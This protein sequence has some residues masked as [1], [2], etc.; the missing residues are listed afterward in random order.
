[1]QATSSGF[2]HFFEFLKCLLTRAYLTVI[3]C[4]LQMEN[5]GKYL[6]FCE[7]QLGVPKGDQFQTVDLYEKQNMANVSIKNNI[8]KT[9]LQLKNVINNPFYSVQDCSFSTV[10]VQGSFVL[11]TKNLFFL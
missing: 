11:V 3:F 7:E 10:I 9:K 1:M 4:L 6:K 8:L 5:I 2:D